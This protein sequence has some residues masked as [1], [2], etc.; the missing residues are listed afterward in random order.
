MGNKVSDGANAPLADERSWRDWFRSLAFSVNN[1][2]MEPTI[3]ATAGASAGYITIYINDVAYKIQVN[4][5]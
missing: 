1:P 4:N 2:R 3:V 5:V